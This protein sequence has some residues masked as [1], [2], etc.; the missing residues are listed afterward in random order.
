VAHDVVPANAAIGAR[1]R[2]ASHDLLAA[3]VAGGLL[4]GA[5]MLA[6]I[7]ASAALAGRSL[8]QPL[9]LTAAT[10]LDRGALDGGAGAVALGLLLWAVVSVALAVLFGAMLPRDFPFV[11]AAALGVAYMFFV[12]ALATSFVLPRVNPV[13]REEMPPM[14]GAWVVAYALFGL[15]LGVVPV[16]RRRFGAR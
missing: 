15:V 14:G 13:M 6:S 3:G 2:S 12:I 10:V 4:A 8:A 1:E 7:T 16:L 5:A 11:S 9:Q